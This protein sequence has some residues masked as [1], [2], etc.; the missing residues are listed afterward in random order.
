MSGITTGTALAIAAGT[1]AAGSIGGALIGANAA[2]N[3]AS[4]QANAANQAANL[5]F[6][7]GQENLGFQQQVFNTQQANERP[8]LQSGAN[9]VT[10]QNQLLGLSPVSS[11]L[12]ALSGSA[13]NA[14][15]VPT[16]PSIGN[17]SVINARPEGKWKGGPVSAAMQPHRY[18]V[19]EKGPEE[20]DLAPGSRGVVIPNNQLRNTNRLIPR[21]QGGQI[22]DPYNYSNSQSNAAAPAQTQP[23]Q[24]VQP[25]TP[26]PAPA[27]G[28]APQSNPYGAQANNP[29][30][31]GGSN[32]PIQNTPY[33]QWSQ[34]FQAPT[35]QQAEQY[36]GYQFAL[37]Q[38]ENAI[39]N[40][41]SALGTTGSGATGAALNNYAQNSAQQDYSNVYNQA[42]GQ[43]QQN[44]NIFN[45]NQA[46]QFNRLASVAGLGQTAAGGLNSSSGQIAGN[47]GSALT[48]TGYGI[49]QQLNN[50]AAAQAS[51]Y[52][53]QAN[54]YSGALSSVG[55]AASLPLYLQLLQSQGASTSTPS[56][57]WVATS[58]YGVESPQ[59][60]VIRHWLHTEAPAWFR[61][62]YI[63][64]GPWIAK[65]PLRWLFKPL[66]E[67]VLKRSGFYSLRE[68]IA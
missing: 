27:N 26:Q 21:L 37:Q 19:G 44:Y 57:C 10:E 25:Y 32:A 48:N 8:W 36:P 5:Q 42:L 14:V 56:C 30:I 2:G 33:T 54:A 11:Q 51:G 55:N 7:L 46:N 13:N 12:P 50:A 22:G 52:V 62:M 63:K 58:F 60:K 61:T 45:Q 59:V 38:G 1:G 53:G 34:Q 47:V 67:S 66:F 9:A 41:A 31:T 3:A 18:L 68:G 64:H 6:Q 16:I 23:N 40:N 17:P 28:Q 29:L 65:T 49:G 35:L 15:Q 39:T 43:Y 4:T 24:S 20:I